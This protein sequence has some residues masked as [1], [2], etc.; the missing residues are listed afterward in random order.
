MKTATVNIKVDQNI[1]E[2]VNT[3]L[4]DLGLNISTAVS[5]LFQ[6]IIHSKGLPFE[7][8]LPNRET[9]NA[10]SELESGNGKKFSNVQDLLKDLKA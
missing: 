2:E 6:Q 4:K 7:V 5:M 3:I 9:V 8:K 10:I 1:K